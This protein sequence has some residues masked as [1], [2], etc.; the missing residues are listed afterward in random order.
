M[1]INQFICAESYE[2]I[3][4]MYVAVENKK[5]F[6]LETNLNEEVNGQ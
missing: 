6:D 4:K 1:I 3:T 5:K 2:G